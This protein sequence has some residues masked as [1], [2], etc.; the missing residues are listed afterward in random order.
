MANY[1]TSTSDKSRKVA[2]LLCIFL[3]L[4]GIHYFYVLRI[5]D[6]FIRMITLN[7]FMLG[8]LYDIIKIACGSFK[9]NVGCPLRQW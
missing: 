4:L 1:T 3:G 8:W 5:K 9:D 7:F 2:L 6:G